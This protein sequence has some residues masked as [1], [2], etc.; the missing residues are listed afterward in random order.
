MTEKKK[1]REGRDVEG[2]SRKAQLYKGEGSERE[3]REN[4][5]LSA[6]DRDRGSAPKSRLEESFAIAT[7]RKRKENYIRSS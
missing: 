2:S 5:P 7:S 4:V 6:P 1:G 3:E